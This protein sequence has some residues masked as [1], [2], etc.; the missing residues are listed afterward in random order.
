MG[1]GKVF[2][3][4]GGLAALLG[5]F[6]FSFSALIPGISLY[7]IGLLLNL[8]SIFT[9]GEIVLIIVTIVFLIFMFAGLFIIIGVKSRGL[10]I[11]GSLFA[12]L[13]SVYILLVIVVSLPPDFAQFILI[14]LE[15][16]LVDGIIPLSVPLGDLS[17]GTYLLLGGGILGLIGGIMGTD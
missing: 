11:L 16:D 6:L 7:G 1:S 9:S 17:L 12:I 15:Q 5:V 3:I 13:L 10:A 2:C 4:I 8:A 14:F